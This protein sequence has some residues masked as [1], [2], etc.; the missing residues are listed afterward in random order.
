M[1]G[2]KFKKRKHNIKKKTN[3]IKYILLAFFSCVSIGYAYLNSFISINGSSSVSK[4]TWD[5]HF[6]NCTVTD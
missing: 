5:I 4:N 3:S 6:E 2:F 1:Y